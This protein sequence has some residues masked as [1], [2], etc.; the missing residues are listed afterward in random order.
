MGKTEC[1]C[2]D[3]DTNHSNPK[4]DTSIKIG[5]LTPTRDFNFVEDTCDAL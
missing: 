2:S 3:T 1:T 4:N 5:A